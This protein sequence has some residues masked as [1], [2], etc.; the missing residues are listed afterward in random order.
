MF[1]SECVFGY[2]FLL[3]TVLLVVFFL[4]VTS[5]LMV[6]T[7]GGETGTASEFDPGKMPFLAVSS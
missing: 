6:K 1:R 5:R 3:F 2:F 4:S 7:A